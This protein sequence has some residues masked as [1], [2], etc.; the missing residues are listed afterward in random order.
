MKH[1]LISS[2]III[3]ALFTACE[4]DDNGPK[5]VEVTGIY[6]VNY[7]NYGATKGSLT[8]IDIVTKEATQSIFKTVNGREMKG[9]PQYAAQYGDKIYF[10]GNELDEV[11]F[12]NANSLKQSKDGIAADIIKPRYFVGEGNYIYVSCWGGNIWDDAS[13]SYIAKIDTAQNKVVNKISCPGGTE[14]LAIANGKLYIALGYDKKIGIMDLNSEVITFIDK[15]PAISSY[16]IKDDKNNLYLT[17]ADSYSDK[18]DSTGLAYI[19]T[20]TDEVDAFYKLALNHN[21]GRMLS[22]NSDYSKLYVLGAAYNDAWEM[23]GG[24]HIFNTKEGKFEDKPLIENVTG[25]KSVTVNPQ[26]NEVYVTDSPTAT[27]DGT[28]TIFDADGSK[29]SAF[30]VGVSPAWSLFIE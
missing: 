14:G 20:N 22:F 4:K 2:L 29:T 26:T 13:T 1:L 19:N 25:L 7:G 15:Q 6:T 21:D 3:A 23:V 8:N 16:F 18:A 30:P 24:I 12:V 11:F 17:Q 5:K 9:N 28:L 27:A 10:M